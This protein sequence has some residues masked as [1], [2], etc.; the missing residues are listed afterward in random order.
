[1]GRTRI[2]GMVFAVSVLL[3]A[4]APGYNSV[5]F[6]TR[7]N[8]G[9]DADTSPP[10][11]EIGIS[12][13]EG[14]FEPAF[15]GG[16]T[17]PVMGSFSS[18]SDAFFRFFLGVRST[19]STGQAAYIMSYLYNDPTRAE[20]IPYKKVELTQ[21]PNPKLP[22]GRQA[23][24][25]EAGKVKPVIFGTDTNL[26]IKVRWSGQTAQYPS[27]VNIGFKR[28]EAAWAPVGLK[29]TPEKKYEVDVPSLLATIDVGVAA[30]RE[31]GVTYLQYFAT[32]SAADNLA[33]RYEVREAML[34]RG[35]PMQAKIAEEGIKRRENNWKY[36]KQI[37][38]SF[39]ATTTDTNK[40]NAIIQK[41][42]E[43]KLVD[44]SVADEKD[45]F[46]AL[47]EHSDGLSPIP[48]KLEELAKFA[49]EK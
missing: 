16:E 36:I 3:Q 11:L 37:K 17:V 38:N 33:R 9:F 14:V 24:Y 32:G 30:E 7:S 1:M 44:A 48:A 8:I 22:F 42:K 27:S 18:E 25:V 20:K 29:V 39:K 41:A 6:A 46:K 13:Q 10:N 35:D 26:G 28:K 34:K 21:K 43:M 5:L 31:A 49:S 45:F 47:G 23:Q 12:R 40:K 2:L 15:E 4:C 19:F